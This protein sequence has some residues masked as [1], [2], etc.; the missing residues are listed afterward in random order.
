MLI[1]LIYLTKQFFQ[2]EADRLKINPNLLIAQKLCLD[3]RKRN[4]DLKVLSIDPKKVSAKLEDYDDRKRWKYLYAQ[5]IGHHGIGPSWPIRPQKNKSTENIIA[6]AFKE[7]GNG[8]HQLNNSL[9]T[10]SK[11]LQD[12]ENALNKNKKRLFTLVKKKMPQEG[13]LLAIELNGKKGGDIEIVRNAFVN[14]KLSGAKKAAIKGQ[15]QCHTC[16]KVTEVSPEMP[17]KFLA[18]IDKPSFSP[19]GDRNRSWTISPFCKECT[20]WLHI[21]EDVLKEILSIRVAGKNAYLIPN[22]DPDSRMTK[23]FLR[24]LLH[25]REDTAKQGL[26][27]QADFFGTMIEEYKWDGPPPF[28]SV[29]LV[30]YQPGQKF[31][32]LHTTAEIFPKNLNRVSE[33]LRRIRDSLRSGALGDVGKKKEEFVRGNLSFVG[34]TWDSK[35][36]ASLTLDPTNLVEAILNQSPP[37]PVVFWSDV[38]ML[39]RSKYL[40]SV[41]SSQF[42][43]KGNITEMAIYTYVIWSLLYTHTLEQVGSVASKNLESAKDLNQHWTDFFSDKT[44]LDAD[45]KRAYFLIGVLFGRVEYAQR[46]ERGSWKGEMPIMSRLRGLTISK[47]QIAKALFPELRMKIRQLSVSSRAIKEIEE[48]ASYYL[49]RES[50]LSDQEARYCFSL[51]WALDFRTQNFIGEK[52]HVKQEERD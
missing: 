17:F 25:F 23:Q 5:L 1:S 48:A 31:L 38:D 15:G 35:G 26:I 29:Q 2:D 37:D 39:L 45:A 28:R 41:S 10:P 42:S 8:L 50:E 52:I 6:S 3:P 33:E 49:S 11:W 40:D 18:I 43:V 51:G 36:K 34:W 14:N 21:S 44:V 20:K 32:F 47:D 16:G 19:Y 30:F 9:Q 24:Y 22:F 13:C 4:Q 7:V 12:A 27:S 46:K